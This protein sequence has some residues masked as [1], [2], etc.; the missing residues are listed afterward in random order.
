MSSTKA[1]WSKDVP[2]A[3][4]LREIGAGALQ[5]PE[6]Q[7]GWTWDDGRIRAILATLTQHYPMGAVMCLECGGTTD[8]KA[9]PFEGAPKTDSEPTHLVLDG[10]QRL[11]SIY[12]AA[13]SKNPVKTKTGKEQDVHR[14]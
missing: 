3:D 2:L 10:Q 5:L 6:F 8:F 7:R 12:G 4:L 1:P 13:W 9:R 11:T 14:Y